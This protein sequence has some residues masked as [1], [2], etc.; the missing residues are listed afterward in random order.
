MKFDSLAESEM[1]AAGFSE[2]GEDGELID[3]SPEDEEPSM[4]DLASMENEEM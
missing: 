3:D 2:V 4:D 1:G